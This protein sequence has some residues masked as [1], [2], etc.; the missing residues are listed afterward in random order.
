MGPYAFKNDQW[1]SFDD[2]DIIKRKVN[3]IKSLGL[4]GGMVWA[5]D[6]DDFKNRYV[7]FKKKSC[8]IT[9]KISTK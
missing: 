2:E 5:V 3:F 1:V 4:A 6:L 9:Y 8:C 7:S